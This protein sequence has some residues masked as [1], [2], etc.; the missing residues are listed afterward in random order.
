MLPGLRCLEV[1][2][3][4]YLFYCSESFCFTST[5][6]VLL[7][8]PLNSLVLEPTSD[9]LR[10]KEQKGVWIDVIIGDPKELLKNT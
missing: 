8:R 2:E 9:G 1:V 10:S 6:Q 7:S 4:H 5:E 3:T